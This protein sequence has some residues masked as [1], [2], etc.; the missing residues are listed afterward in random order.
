MRTRLLG[1]ESRWFRILAMMSCCGAWFPT[2]LVVI[3][4]EV[5]YRKIDHQN[6]NSVTFDQPFDKYYILADRGS[7][8]NFSLV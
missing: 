4:F 7:F 6:R 1:L 5:D 2:F 3:Y 8:L